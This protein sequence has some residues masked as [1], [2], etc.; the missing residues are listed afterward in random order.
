[1][2]NRCLDA[3]ADAPRTFSGRAFLLLAVVAV[4]LRTFKP[5]ELHTLLV[6]DPPLRQTLGLVWVPHR[7]TIERRLRATLP[8]AEAQVQALGQQILLEVSLAPMRPRRRRLMDG[9]TKPKGPSGMP[10][11]ASKAGCPPACAMWTWS[12]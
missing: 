10:A 9:C 4:V 6:K 11:T 1:M 5:Q 3:N 12:R 8:E 2:W 7:R